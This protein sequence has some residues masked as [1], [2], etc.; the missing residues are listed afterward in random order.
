MK[1]IAAASLP[2]EGLQAGQ[3]GLAHIH[4]MPGCWEGLGKGQDQTP[5]YCMG[6][7]IFV[8]YGTQQ[9]WGDLC[10]AGLQNAWKAAHEQQTQIS[11]KP[12]CC[13]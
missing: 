8:P 5:H 11:A 10:G 2:Q 12:P 1:S 6:L 7:W 9:K 13:R 3:E 4:S